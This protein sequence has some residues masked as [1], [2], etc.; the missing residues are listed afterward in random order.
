MDFE[1]QTATFKKTFAAGISKV[2]TIHVYDR[3]L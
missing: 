1:P 2:Y 3:T